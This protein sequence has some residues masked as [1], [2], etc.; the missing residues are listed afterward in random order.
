MKNRRILL[1]KNVID[2]LIKIGG[3]ISENSSRK[4][5]E[6]LGQVLYDIYINLKKF[7]VSSGGGIFAEL[8]RKLQKDFRFSDEIAHWMAIYGMEQHSLFLKEFIPNSILIEVKDYKKISASQ[9]NNVP[10]LKVMDFMRE[11]SSLMHNWDST[12]DAIACEI[13]IYLDFKQII[14]LK[15]IDGVYVNGK[16]VPEISI[17]ELLSLKTSPLDP[18]TP[19]LLKERNI[20]SYIINGLNPLRLKDFINGKEIICT[21]II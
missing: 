15:D 14:F 4:Q 6:T 8:I 3:S 2:T 12:S 11:N 20:T 7:L 21:K 13:A 1:S 19:M 5:I 10:I 16:I 18:T 17:D 9:S